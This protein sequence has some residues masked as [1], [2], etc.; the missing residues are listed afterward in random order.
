MPITNTQA[1]NAKPK[2]KLYR[3]NDGTKEKTGEK[4]NGLQRE[5]RPSGAKVWIMRYRDPHTKKGTVLTI[6]KYPDITIRQARD[7]A[8]KAKDLIKQGTSPNRKKQ[9]QRA[10]EQE[11]TFETIARGWH[12]NQL[13]RWSTGNADQV[14]DCLVKDVFPFI[15]SYPLQDLE[16][17]D[18]L[19]VIRRV[20]S[21]GA[22][23]KAAKVKQR[24]GAV[25]RY[26][27]ATGRA[28]YNPVPDLQGAL[29]AF[30]GK[31]YNALTTDQLPDFLRDL[32]GYRSE[33]L[34][35]GVQ[36]ALMTFARTGSI[37]MAEWSE[38][39]WED[40]AWNIPAEHMKMNHAHIIPLPDQAL[41]LLEELHPFT[42]DSRFIFYTTHKEQAL[43]SNALLQVIRRIGWNDR[44]TVHGFRALASSTLHEAGFPPHI[45][46][47]QLAHAERN[48][49]AGAYN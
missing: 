2:E 13:G 15:G 3:L 44:T 48:K 38:I 1:D 4:G 17:P 23:D 37:R 45:I 19:Q 40:K 29:K 43:S 47:R 16:V 34:R 21:R 33:V 35:R 10:T 24:I 20:E 41:K 25:Y 26:A 42:G 22:L 36:F 28:K 14:M 9:Q 8:G 6:G 7:E 11:S 27:V 39:D 49:V 18:L 12:S 32:S 5:I 46:E 31:H 30:K